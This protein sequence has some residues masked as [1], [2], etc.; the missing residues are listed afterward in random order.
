MQTCPKANCPLWSYLEGELSAVVVHAAGVHEAERVLHRDLA[1]HFL[2][3]QRTDAAVSQRRRH[4][5]RRL[6]CHLHRAQ[7]TTVMTSSAQINIHVR[8]YN[9]SHTVDSTGPKSAAEQHVTSI[10]AV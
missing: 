10:I 6:A 9:I 7:L 4:H 8:S 2:S 3:R 1:E 5:R